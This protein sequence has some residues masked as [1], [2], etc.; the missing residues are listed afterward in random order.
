MARTVQTHTVEKQNRDQGKTFIITEMSA[1]A[2]HKWATKAIFAVMN[3]GVEIPDDV[4]AMGMAGVAVLG[5]A[6]LSNIPY[7]VAEPLLNELLDC[8]QIKQELTTRALWMDD[9]FEEATTIFDLQRL[10][11]TMHIEPFISGGNR[12]SESPPTTPAAAG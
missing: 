12:S 7:S 6:A 3:G 10:V 8:V 9:D 4:A 5:M 11:L 2:A 1:R